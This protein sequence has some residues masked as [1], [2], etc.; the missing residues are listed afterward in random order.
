MENDEKSIAELIDR[1]VYDVT[2]RLP[3]L[4]RADIEKELRSLIEDML[5]AKAKRDAPTKQQ[6]LEVLRELG[7]P[8]ALAAQYRGTKQY[9]IGPDT[10][11]MYFMI[12]KIVLAATGFGMI[13][14][15]V[16]GYINS[17]PQNPIEAF[18]NFL[19]TVLS[20]LVEAFA[21]VTVIF[22]LAERYMHGK[23]KGKEWDPLDL[24]PIPH[25]KAEIKRSEPIVG[26]VFSIIFLIIVQ[27]APW[28]FGVYSGRHPAAL[29]FNLNVWNAMVPWMDAM[30]CLG[31]LKEIF[32]FLS[33]KYTVRLAVA[34]TVIDILT[35]ILFIYIFLPPAIWNA[36]FMTSLQNI[37]GL[38]WAGSAEASNLWNIVPKILVGIAAFGHIIDIAVTLA[39]AFRYE[40]R[41][42]ADPA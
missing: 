12:L 5:S 23:W 6:L 26:I 38:A 37:N 32:R 20:S 1:Y 27:T 10:F 35:L 8:S 4:Q 40:P 3:Q 41:H 17:P 34:V 21:W 36:N 33:G 15:L 31:I 19:A 14:A 2:R 16:I 13:L 22:A 25:E 24:P 11:D 18:A 30:I 7:R 9:L 28:L 39:R 42:T 29:V